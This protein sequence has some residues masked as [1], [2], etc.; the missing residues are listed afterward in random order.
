MA[1]PHPYTTL[2]G[3]GNSTHNDSK[4][5]LDPPSFFTQPD[6][7]RSLTPAVGH[8]FSVPPM[9]SAARDWGAPVVT[10]ILPGF[11]CAHY[12]N[13]CPATRHSSSPIFPW[14]L[15]AFQ[16]RACS[17]GSPGG[18]GAFICTPVHPAASHFAGPVVTSHHTSTPSACSAITLRVGTPNFL[19]DEESRTGCHLTPVSF[20]P[21]IF[22]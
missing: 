18:G 1:C 17:Q 6:S 13:V 3:P 7:T 2:F 20:S 9:E 12:L 4:E 11:H 19:R 14:R 10:H 8:P 21:G 22:F 15:W 5:T 16:E